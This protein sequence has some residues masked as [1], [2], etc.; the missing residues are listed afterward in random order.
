MEKKMNETP[1]FQSRILL[2]QENSI[3][4]FWYFTILE[5]KMRTIEILQL[6]RKFFSRTLMHEHASTAHA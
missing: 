2:L 1:S 4:G 3:N 5:Q 6:S